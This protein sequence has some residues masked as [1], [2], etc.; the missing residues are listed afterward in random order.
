[1][2][3]MKRFAKIIS[4]GQTGVDRAG[5]DVAMERGL[6]CGGWCPKGRKTEAGPLPEQYP[7]QE[8]KSATYAERTR[9]NVCDSDGTLILTRSKPKG[10]TALTLELAKKM[11]KPVLVL[12]LSE[13]PDPKTVR[14][15][16][17]RH[18]VKVLN[19]AGPRASENPGIYD[20]AAEFLRELF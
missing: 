4:G 19:I 1:M 11:K 14:Q 3:L 16:A 6:A 10:G 8:T 2:A 18:K 9:L 15:W 20:D 17:K 12:D 5:L 7:L 13:D